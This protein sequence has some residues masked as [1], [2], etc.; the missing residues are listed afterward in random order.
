LGLWKGDLLLG[1]AGQSLGTVSIGHPMVR[2][3]MLTVAGHPEK[4][5]KWAHAFEPHVHDSVALFLE[6]YGCIEEALK[7]PMITPRLF[8]DLCIKHQ[9]TQHVLTLA[10]KGIP[11]LDLCD[12]STDCASVLGLTE[13]LQSR[14]MQISAKIR[15]GAYLIQMDEKESVKE[16]IQACLS[17]GRAEDACMLALLLGDSQVILD[18]SMKTRNWSIAALQGVV[19]T[20]SK[21]RATVSEAG[22]F[23]SWN[24][25][26]MSSPSLAY[27]VGD[28]ENPSS[29]R[30]LPEVSTA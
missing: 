9:K 5:W 11:F 12:T 1:L 21:S 6:A 7:V 17:H 14:E 3:A 30:V 28:E 26:Q 25:E 24:D 19:E 4:A 18:T 29:M 13:P 22:I 23:H 16:L 2:L 8:L 10:K 15:I 20:K 27:L